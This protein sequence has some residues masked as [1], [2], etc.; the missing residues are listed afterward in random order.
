MTQRRQNCLVQIPE[1][2]RRAPN[3]PELQGYPVLTVIYAA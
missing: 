2:N 1:I 3:P